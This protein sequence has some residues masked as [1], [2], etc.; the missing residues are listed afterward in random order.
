MRNSLVATGSPQDESVRSANLW[1]VMQIGGPRQQD[2]PQ[3]RGYGAMSVTPIANRTAD[4]RLER[5][6]D[7]AP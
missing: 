2:G 5:S 4:S 1:S 7:P 6:F 3:G